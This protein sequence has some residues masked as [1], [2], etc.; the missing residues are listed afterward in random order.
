MCFGSY[1]YYDY[2]SYRNCVRNRMMPFGYY[3]EDKLYQANESSDPV[4]DILK[5]RYA[6]GEINKEEFEQMKGDLQ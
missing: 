5:Q 1:R 3:E 6:K 2:I 4:L